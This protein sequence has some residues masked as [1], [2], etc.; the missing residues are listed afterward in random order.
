MSRSLSKKE[1]KKSVSSVWVFVV[2]CPF[3]AHAHC[4]KWCDHSNAENCVDRLLRRVILLLYLHHL[5]ALMRT[6]AISALFGMLKS[7]RC[8]ARKSLHH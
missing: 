5:F 4:E 7:S 6:F 1:G 2:F 8:F 3:C